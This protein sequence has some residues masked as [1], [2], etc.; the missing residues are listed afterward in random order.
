MPM[1]C[2]IDSKG[3]ALRLIYGFLLIIAGLLLAFFWALPADRAWPW[4]VAVSLTAS[5]AFAVFE[6]WAG[7]CVLRALG[8]KT[9]L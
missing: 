1:Q 5:G 6:G 2:N 9:P 7:W 3:K 4:I 8:L